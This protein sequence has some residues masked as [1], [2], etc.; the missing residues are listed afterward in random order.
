MTGEA[1]PPVH[2]PPLL[3]A[4]EVVAGKRKIRFGELLETLGAGRADARER[5]GRLE[6]DGLIKSQ[7]APS[8]LE[9]LG[10]YSVTAKGLAAE[11]RLRRLTPGRKCTCEGLEL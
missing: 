5:L 3:R 7:D 8:Q 1:L 2:D 11:R 10:W 6:D 9:D 4:F